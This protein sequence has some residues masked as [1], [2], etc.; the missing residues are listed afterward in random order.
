MMYLS[1]LRKSTNLIKTSL[2][3][4]VKTS[5]PLHSY[6]CNILSNPFPVEIVSSRIGNVPFIKY[7]ARM[8]EWSLRLSGQRRRHNGTRT[9]ARNIVQ[10]A[11]YSLIHVPPHLSVFG[12]RAILIATRLGDVPITNGMR[13]GNAEVPNEAPILF[14]ARPKV[15]Q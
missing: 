1:G 3:K 11:K 15:K 4:Q 8:P 6:I 2:Q 12:H 14:R 9:S 10:K 7:Q 5:I 13:L